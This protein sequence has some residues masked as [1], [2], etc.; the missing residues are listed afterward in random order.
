M[1]THFPIILH[2]ITRPYYIFLATIRTLNPFT[3]PPRMSTCL[4]LDSYHTILI[5][6]NIDWWYWSKYWSMI[7]IEILIDVLDWKI[8]NLDWNIDWLMIL[9]EIL[10]DDLTTLLPKVVVDHVA[11]I[12]HSQMSWFTCQHTLIRV[13]PC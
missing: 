13:A 4:T 1:I 3:H 10:I 8:D 7:L 6:W 2:N 12:K 5:Q 9:I 11:L